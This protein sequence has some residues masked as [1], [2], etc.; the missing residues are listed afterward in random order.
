MTEHESNVYEVLRAIASYIGN[1][2]VNGNV[3]LLAQAIGT[4]ETQLS[5]VFKQLEVEGRIGAV[6]REGDGFYSVIVYDVDE[7]GPYSNIPVLMG[8]IE[9]NTEGINEVIL[10]GVPGYYVLED[11]V[12]T[13]RVPRYVGRSDT[14][15]R[16]ELI[17][18]ISKGYP[19]AELFYSPSAEQAY[20]AECA[21]YHGFGPEELTNEV[22]PDMPNGMHIECPYCL[23]GFDRRINLDP[24]QKMKRLVKLFQEYK[25]KSR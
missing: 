18:R 5:R 3:H 13:I 7:K 10:D 6:Y 23:H 4:S 22:H 15:L 1:T 17:E 8:P 25:K 9:M 19:L 20:Y 14:N 2:R 24:N 12:E 11:V 21:L 16:V